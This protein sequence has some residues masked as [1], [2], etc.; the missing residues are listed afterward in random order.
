MVQCDVAFPVNAGATK[1]PNPAA[2]S[3]VIVSTEVEKSAT[4]KGILKYFQLQKAGVHCSF[5]GRLLRLL[6]E[7]KCFEMFRALQP[8]HLFACSPCT[9]EPLKS[10]SIP[11]EGGRL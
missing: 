3:H 9:L 11:R 4:S 8:R 7:N 6:Q 2:G 1:A 5:F 10:L